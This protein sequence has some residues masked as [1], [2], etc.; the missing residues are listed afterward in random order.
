MMAVQYLSSHLCSRLRLGRTF[1]VAVRIDKLQSHAGHLHSTA[2]VRTS[3]SR[4][5]KP[6]PRKKSKALVATDVITDQMSYFLKINK[7]IEGERR[8]QSLLVKTMK[9]LLDAIS[10][11]REQLQLI[12]PWFWN[13]VE[14]D[15]KRQLIVECAVEGFQKAGVYPLLEDGVFTID[16]LVKSAPIASKAEV[17]GVYARLY[18]AKRKSGLY[19]GS[20]GNIMSRM[21]GHN[22]NL[23]KA[24]GLQANAY[25]RAIGKHQRVL[26]DLNDNTF[27]QQDEHIRLVIEQ[28][29]VILLGTYAISD[30]ENSIAPGCQQ[31]ERAH[32][33][34]AP[35]RYVKMEDIVKV[36][37]GAVD[38]DSDEEAL[39]IIIRGRSARTSLELAKLGL[40]VC[41]KC[42][43]HPITARL[44]PNT[45]FGTRVAFGTDISPLNWFSPID[46]II[47]P[48][49]KA[50]KANSRT[51]AITIYRKGTLEVVVA[52]VATLD[53]QPQ[54]S[55]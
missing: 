3:D 19:I 41:T 32:A 26:C 24:R 23:P 29:L 37:P 45:K 12:Q 9:E 48:S 7:L 2:P 39:S 11:S 42:G 31:H 52:P 18:L 46:T 53:L 40:E 27:A 20:S 49:A 25:A 16:Q 28:L 17:P 34:L 50:T 15:Q 10:R 22:K 55:T 8:K 35:S 33:K 51:T 38:G 54:A 13:L 47:P 1:A 30:I 21:K 4:S 36:E 6:L 5:V 44:D 43:W 14:T